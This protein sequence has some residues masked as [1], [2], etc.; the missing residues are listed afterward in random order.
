MNTYSIN[1][2]NPKAKVI[3]ENL[4][5]LKLISINVKEDESKMDLMSLLTKL[6]KK[7]SIA[8]SPEEIQK[9]VKKVRRSRACPLKSLE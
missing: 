2:L 5:D 8:P 3:L 4:A 9:E 6:R 1:I 7:S